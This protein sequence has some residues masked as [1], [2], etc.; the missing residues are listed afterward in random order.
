MSLWDRGFVDAKTPRRPCLHPTIQDSSHQSP[1]WMPSFSSSL[2]NWAVERNQGSY[3]KME[4]IRAI[5]EKSNCRMLVDTFFIPGVKLQFLV[6]SGIGKCNNSQITAQRRLSERAGVASSP[7]RM[8]PV[9]VSHTKALRGLQSPL[10]SYSIGQT[11]QVK[12]VQAVSIP[13]FSIIS[14]VSGATTPVTFSHS[15]LK[16]LLWNP[17]ELHRR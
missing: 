9:F 5:N 7:G 14:R 13:T 12:S 15:V 17:N 2:K 1:S 8:C 10:S 6:P 4:G 16:L 3:E 11:I